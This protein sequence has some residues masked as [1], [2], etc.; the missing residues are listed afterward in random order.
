MA[1]KPVALSRK[2]RDGLLAAARAVRARAYAPYSRFPV[3]AA[4]LGAS[5]R[6]YVG[7]NVENASFGAT[8]CA[9]RAAVASAIA[10]GEQRVSA[11]A[12]VGGEKDPVPP[13]GIC[14]QTLAEFGS[15]DLRVVLAAPDAPGVTVTTLGEVMPLRFGRSHLT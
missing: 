3:G 8:L 4:L 10:A 11:I 13:C 9:E 7:C 14:L 12:V 15:G 1:K 2:A 6:M 5:G